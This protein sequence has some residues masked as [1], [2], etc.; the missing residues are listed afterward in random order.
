MKRFQPLRKCAAE[1]CHDPVIKGWWYCKGHYF[2]LPKPMRDVLWRAWRG[3]NNPACTSL[4]QDQRTALHDAYQ[5]AFQRCQ[6]HLL[7]TPNTPAA[8]MATVAIGADGREIHYAE[9]RRL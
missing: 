1:G 2:S 6:R 8:A 4:S 5:Y 9:G 3:W 7:T